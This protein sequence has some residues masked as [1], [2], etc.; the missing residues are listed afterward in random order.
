MA[1][2]A[3]KRPIQVIAIVT[4]EL[5]Q[6]LMQELQEAADGTQQRIE[7]MEFQGRRYLADV[8]RNNLTQAMA[9]R[10][11][12]EKEKTKYEDIKK[13]LQQRMQEVTALELGSEYARGTLESEVQIAEGDNLFEKL[14]RAQVVIKDGVIQEIRE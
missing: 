13:E 4:E 9:V 7:Q 5:K 1:S 10:Q 2:I 6:E 14:G 3:V 12:I 11:Q 8:Q